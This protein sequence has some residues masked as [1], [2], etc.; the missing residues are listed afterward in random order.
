MADPDVRI[1]VRT[2]SA[3]AIHKL[4]DYCREG[5]LNLL[6]GYDLTEPVR[7]AILALPEDAWHG[8]I[9]QDGEPREARRSRRSPVC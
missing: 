5:R 9:R 4:A 8:A 7:Q 3:G 6:A 2:D 1:V